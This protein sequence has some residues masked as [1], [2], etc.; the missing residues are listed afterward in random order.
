MVFK[1][2]L[3]ELRFTGSWRLLLNSKSQKRGTYRFDLANI[4]RQFLEYYFINLKA[5]FVT[6]Y[7]HKDLQTLISDSNRMIGL[8]NDLDKLVATQPSLLL[9]KWLKDAGNMGK[10]KSEQ[11]YF[12]KDA[13]NILTTWGGQGQSLNDYANRSWSGLLKDFYATRWKM[14]IHRVITAVKANVPFDEK[15]FDEEVKAFEWQWDWLGLICQSNCPK[16]N[17]QLTPF[18]LIVF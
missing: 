18:N 1:Y 6:E 4:G 9:G 17:D 2:Q 7:N 13:R 15:A 14:L 16:I 12:R 11:L 5:Q 3:Q 10:N 8:I